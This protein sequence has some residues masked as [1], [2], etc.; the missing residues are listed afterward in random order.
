MLNKMIMDIKAILKEQKEYRELNKREEEERC[1]WMDNYI[2]TL[3]KKK[4][5][6]SLKYTSECM[7]PNNKKMQELY[8]IK[9]FEK[10]RA[11]YVLAY[12]PGMFDY[13][14]E[15]VFPSDLELQSEY[16]KY[17]EEKKI[18][19]ENELKRQYK[20]FKRKH[21]EFVKGLLEG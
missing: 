7:F 13:K 10:L 9:Q 21:M 2:S 8:D 5:A 15:H 16:V 12:T 17:K 11:K 6:Y 19:Y 18:K 1:K 20:I 4:H 14:P 3:P